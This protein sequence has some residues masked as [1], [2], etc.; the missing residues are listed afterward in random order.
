MYAV[1]ADWPIET[2]SPTFQVYFVGLNLLSLLA[3]GPVSVPFGPAAGLVAAIIVGVIVG[4]VLAHR[5]DGALITRAVLV[6]AIAGGSV[7]VVRGVVRG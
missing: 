2:A 4:T 6:L 7:A 1:N 5:L 3:L